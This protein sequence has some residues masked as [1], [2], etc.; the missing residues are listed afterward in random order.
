MYLLE[1]INPNLNVAGIYLQKILNLSIKKDKKKT[2]EDLKF[3]NLKLQGLTLNDESILPDIDSEYE[4]SK[5]IQSLKTKKDGELKGQLYSYEDKE[6]FKEK[7]KKIITDCINNVYDA[8][9]PIRPYKIDKDT[10]CSYCSFK[11]I[12][13]KNENQYK[14]IKIEKEDKEG[15]Q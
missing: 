8:D 6:D 12:C 7:I 5:I 9:F 14:I 10:G 3:D 15:E 13:F 4:S 1:T 2:E 11:D